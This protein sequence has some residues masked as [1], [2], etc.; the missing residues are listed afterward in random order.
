MLQQSFDLQ[1]FI[2]QRLFKKMIFHRV[3]RRAPLPLGASFLGYCSLSASPSSSSSSAPIAAR[4]YSAPPVVAYCTDVEGCFP[5]W[6]R[7][8]DQVSVCLCNSATRF[9]TSRCDGIS[10]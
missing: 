6:E 2:V 1:I 3:L 4:S 10:F 7:Y 9:V 8:V 5:F